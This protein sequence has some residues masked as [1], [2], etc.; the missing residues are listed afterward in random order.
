MLI[1]QH[2]KMFIKIIVTISIIIIYSTIFGLFVRSFR[3]QLECQERFNCIRFCSTDVDRYSDEYLSNDFLNNES[4]KKWLIHRE[5]H[6][7]D[8]DE[9]KVYRGSPVCG[10]LSYLPTKNEL[11]SNLS[12]YGF[13]FVSKASFKI[14]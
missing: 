2:K 8:I 7:I 13:N 3:E 6:S 11:N 12:I 10:G 14:F 4:G 9:V 1:H 5:Y